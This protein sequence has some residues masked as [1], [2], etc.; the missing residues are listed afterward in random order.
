MSSN[1]V[2]TYRLIAELNTY[3]R[4]PLLAREHGTVYLLPHTTSS[5]KT[6][7]LTFWTIIFIVTIMHFDYVQRSCTL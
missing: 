4:S 1:I 7:N 6:L 3:Y 5:K 2:A